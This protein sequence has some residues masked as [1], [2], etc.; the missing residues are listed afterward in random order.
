M[1]GCMMMMVIVMIMMMLKLMRRTMVMFVMKMLGSDRN[2]K[3]RLNLL[4]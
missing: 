1:V 3:S 2:L 4:W